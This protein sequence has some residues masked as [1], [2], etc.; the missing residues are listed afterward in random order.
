MK[1]N[2]E[3]EAIRIIGLARSTH[4]AYNSLK[5]RFEGKTITDLGIILGGIT[6]CTYDDRKQTIDEH[7]DEYEKRWNFMDATLTAEIGEED[8]KLK[9]FAESLTKIAANDRA[10][11]EFLLLMLPPFYSGLVENLP[12]KSS[13]TYGDILRQIKMYALMR[14]KVAKGRGQEEGT[15]EAP[16]V[17]KTNGEKENGK[18][19]TYYQSE[20]WRGNNHTA[21]KCFT[22][23]REEKKKGKDKSGKSNK[24][25]AGTN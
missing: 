11:A 8:E 14:Q 25:K 18:P 10:K 24:S 3:P 16:V 1:R 5:A 9:Y 17:F 20:G 15:S 21:E 23:K 13:Y 6:R 19:C 12:T 22:R 7:I 2:C 4:D